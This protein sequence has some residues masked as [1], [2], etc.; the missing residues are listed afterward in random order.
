MGWKSNL[1][2]GLW[3]RRIKRVTDGVEVE[4]MEVKIDNTSI[5]KLK[6]MKEGD[7]VQVWPNDQRKTDNSPTHQLRVRTQ[8]ND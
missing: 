5:E 6:R 2:T 3:S 4:Y 7:Y 8:T 1:I